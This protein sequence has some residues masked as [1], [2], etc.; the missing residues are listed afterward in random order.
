MGSPFCLSRECARQCVRNQKLRQSLVPTGSFPSISFP[1]PHR[2]RTLPH[3]EAATRHLR[4]LAVQLGAIPLPRDSTTPLPLL[5]GYVC[6]VWVVRCRWSLSLCVSVFVLLWM[7][8]CVR[9][10]MW[11]L[12]LCLCLCDYGCPRA[13]VSVWVCETHG[14]RYPCPHTPQTH[15][16]PHTHRHPPTPAT[17][18]PLGLPIRMGAPPPTP[19]L[20]L[21]LQREG[22]CPHQVWLCRRV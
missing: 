10:C 9:V 21:P 6:V 11:C 17:P 16:P 2:Q 18:C 8:V 20:L 12:Y 3:P 13:L 5:Q 22:T 4:P 14:E 1:S 19:G 15:T 7:R